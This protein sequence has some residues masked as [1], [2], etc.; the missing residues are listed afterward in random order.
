MTRESRGPWYLLT[1]VIIGFI[2][3]LLY[4]WVFSPA[5]YVDTHPDAL[6]ADYKDAYRAAIAAAYSVTEDMTR[7]QARL[8]L[9]NEEDS[10]S[11]LAA[12]S[13]HYLAEG[14]SYEAA[15]A[16]ARLSAALG[17]VPEPA[18]RTA[19]SMPAPSETPLPEDTA[20]VE[21]NATEETELTTTETVE[22]PNEST[23]PEVV[24]DGLPTSTSNISPTPTLTRTPILTFTP[25]P[26]RTPTPTLAPPFV[27][28]E[29]ALVC[30][31][32]I[33]DSLI[34]ILVQ[35]ALGDGIPGVKIIIH[36][37][38]QEEHFFT[39]LKPEMG[40]GYADYSM[41]PEISYT[42]NIG[43]G[44]EP[45][46]LFVPECSD[47]QGERYWGGWRLIFAHP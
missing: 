1:G 21:L 13:Q 6:R 37:D 31:Q 44:G 4:T 14:Y 30:D 35:N 23:T 46:D 24:E 36:W 9:L 32:E 7:A 17:E 15:L 8:S 16:L 20:T 12:Q 42:L 38:G 10:A 47:D 2:V 28:R 18:P 19:T 5:E 43:E 39:G 11:I 3:G 45:V 33:E 41:T 27:M 40:W 25:L 26:T 34:Q 22:S 29:Q